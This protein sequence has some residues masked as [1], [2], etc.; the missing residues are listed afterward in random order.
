LTSRRSK[1][2]IVLD[3]LTALQ[4]A[5]EGLKFTHLL[6][7]SNLA[8]QRLHEYV[9]NLLDRGLVIKME[10]GSIRTGRHS[11]NGKDYYCLTD[12]GAS[13]LEDLQKY[14]KAFEIIGIRDD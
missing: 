14:K 7:R 2:E 4:K 10:A 3:I 1:Q 9:D 8:H 12:K 11:Y 13:V 5:P 6:Y